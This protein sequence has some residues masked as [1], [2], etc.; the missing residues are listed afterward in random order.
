M[1]ASALS[2]VP[3]GDPQLRVTPPRAKLLRLN[4]SLARMLFTKEFEL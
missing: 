4:E 2:R 1:R 3:L